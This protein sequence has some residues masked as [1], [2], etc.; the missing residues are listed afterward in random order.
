M[1]KKHKR[2]FEA[3]TAIGPADFI[4]KDYQQKKVDE[5]FKKS[6]RE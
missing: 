2:A 6:T 5:V 4:I 3:M 1:L